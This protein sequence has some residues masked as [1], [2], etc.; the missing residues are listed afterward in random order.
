MILHQDFTLIVLASLASY[1][2]MHQGSHL[3]WLSAGHS[4]LNPTLALLM[5]IEKY[6]SPIFLIWYGF[7]TVWYNPLLLIAICFPGTI[8]L[9]TIER[10]LGLTRKAWVISISGI[11][12][13]PV[14]L[15]FMVAHINTAGS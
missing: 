10:T 15:Y 6:A 7:K 4:Q 2:T 8:V 3:A 1:F 12:F 5:S 11:L 9:V 14:L 13:V